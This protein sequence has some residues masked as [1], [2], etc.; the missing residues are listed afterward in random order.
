MQKLYSDWQQIHPKQ[1]Q[2]GAYKTMRIIIIKKLFHCCCC[3][4]FNSY[5]CKF[6]TNSIRQFETKL[7]FNSIMK[8]LEN[9]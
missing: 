4:F 6:S 5:C 3:A 1:P 7:I 9:C 8:V 2:Q